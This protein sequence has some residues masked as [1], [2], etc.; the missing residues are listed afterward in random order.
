M[1]SPV[2]DYAVSLGCHVTSIYTDKMFIQ[3]K[4]NLWLQFYIPSPRGFDPYDPYLGIIHMGNTWLWNCGV[5]ESEQDM[6]YLLLDF[7]TRC[8]AAKLAFLRKRVLTTPV[9]QLQALLDE[10]KYE[11]KMS[12][13][14]RYVSRC[15]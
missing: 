13:Y 8:N 2:L 1:R 15:R 14:F 7:V 12:R 4:P 10:I 3:E 9:N 6:F 11:T 5:V